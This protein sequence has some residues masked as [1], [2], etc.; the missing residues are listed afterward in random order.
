VS[1]TKISTGSVEAVGGQLD[2]HSIEPG[3]PL[4]DLPPHSKG[5]A[6]TERRER[7][8]RKTV[9][10]AVNTLDEA[11]MIDHKSFVQNVFDTVALK[12]LEWLTPRN[13]NILAASE[14]EIVMTAENSMSPSTE[15]EVVEPRLQDSGKV[16]ECN[17]RNMVPEDTSESKHGNSNLSDIP[18]LSSQMDQ[19]SRLER[20]KDNEATPNLH[21]TA[22]TPPCTTVSHPPSPT[23]RRKPDHISPPLPKGVLN[24]STSPKSPGSTTDT[25]TLSRE[26]LGTRL[27]RRASQQ[28]SMTNPKLQI[29]KST[30]SGP[31][32]LPSSPREKQA[33]KY[34]ILEESSQTQNDGFLLDG[35]LAK[36]STKPDTPEARTRVLKNEE[37]EDQLLPQT[38][39]CLT[40]ETINYICDVLQYNHTVEKHSLYPETIEFMHQKH[41]EKKIIYNGRS[42]PG[43]T[44]TDE[45]YDWQ[46]FIEQ[47][48]F[49]VLSRPDSLL[50]SF[51]ITERPILD[52]QSIWYLML[53][54]TRVAPSLVFDS[55][56]IAAGALFH[57]PEKI[58]S[59]YE[60]PQTLLPQATTTARNLSNFDAARFM[61]ICLHA[62]VA[63][64]PLVSTARQLANMSRI[65]SYGWTMLG[66]NMT[67]LEP[68]TVCLQYDDAFS[69]EL[70]LRLA[71]RLFAAIP[72]RRRFTELL[73]LQ[74]EVRS[75]ET[76]EQ[77]ILE[78]VLSMIKVLDTPPVLNFQKHERDLHE[79]RA[80]T[81]ILDWARMVMMRD[82]DGAGEVPGDGPFG[83]ALAMMAAICESLAQM[84]WLGF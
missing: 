43:K 61:N 68:A 36:T 14:D 40:I 41:Q 46:L 84:M 59:V 30:S 1:V 28:D 29:A 63:T 21:A 69:N 49:D 62:L 7:S 81:L 60:W 78:A 51:C 76:R 32:E 13:L 22:D 45:A 15:E 70:A 48:L 12:M 77:D 57:P 8:R 26:I 35:G 38:L 67:A 17:K 54:M 10:P 19:V 11:T 82:W 71:R 18:R 83:G 56:W 16:E 44:A 52:T 6:R 53:R 27:Q 34:T 64:A 75:E 79:K 24:I 80:P 39:S 47:S 20:L 72:I 58:E 2:G 23:L 65:R 9:R 37:A 33:S 25:K 31:D 4:A 3:T 42:I 74:R 73:E 66:R 55:L 50:R 5:S